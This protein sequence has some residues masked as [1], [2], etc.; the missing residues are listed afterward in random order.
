MKIG[1][2][3][4]V[5]HSFELNYVKHTNMEGFRRDSGKLYMNCGIIAVIMG[6]ILSIIGKKLSLISSLIDQGFMV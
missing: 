1:E 5:V 6:I 3:I 4:G 2:S